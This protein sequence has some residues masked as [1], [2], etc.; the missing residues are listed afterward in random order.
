MDIDDEHDD[1]IEGAE[2][3]CV[4]YAAYLM[5]QKWKVMLENENFEISRNSA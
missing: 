4:S 5:I 3:S 1:S 2:Y